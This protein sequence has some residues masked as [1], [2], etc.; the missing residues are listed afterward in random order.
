[1]Y[2]SVW[3]RRLAGD[4]DGPSVLTAILSGRP[5]LYLKRSILRSTIGRGWAE[6]SLT[7]LVPGSVP[8]EGIG[9]QDSSIP[10]PVLRIKS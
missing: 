4:N 3:L 7:T 1:M 8:E 9:A 5:Q 2:Y 10:Y 6:K